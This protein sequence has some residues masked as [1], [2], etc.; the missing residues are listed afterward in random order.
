VNKFTYYCAT[1]NAGLEY[2]IY[3][4]NNFLRIPEIIHKRENLGYLCIEDK[5]LY[6]KYISNPS[7]V[8]KLEFNDGEC[9]VIIG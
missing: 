6:S 4:Q 9:V 7:A 5:F 1:S 3:D 8:G 2:P